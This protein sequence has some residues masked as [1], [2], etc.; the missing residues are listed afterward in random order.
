MVMSKVDTS[1]LA[2]AQQDPQRY[3]KWKEWLNLTVQIKL[4]LL[5]GAGLAYGDVHAGNFG[6][7]LNQL[8]NPM[9]IVIYDYSPFTIRTYPPGQVPVDEKKQI[10]EYNTP[11]MFHALDIQ[12]GLAPP[13]P[14]PEPEMIQSQS[15]RL[16]SI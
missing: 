9:D 3:T 4:D 11:Y 14:E 16:S 1:L 13:D 12:L 7:L 8:G 15:G 10:L 5:F 6:L 2:W